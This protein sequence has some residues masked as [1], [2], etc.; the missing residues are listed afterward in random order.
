MKKL[1]NYIGIFVILLATALSCQEDDAT[2]GEINAPSNLE[3]TTEIVG[4]SEPDF[5]N[6]DGSGNVIITATADKAISYKFLFS[7]QT[8]QNSPSGEYTKQFTTTGVNTYTITVI[9]YGTGGTATTASVEVTVLSN[10]SDD[11][12]VQ[13]LTAGTSKVWYW[14]AAQPGHLGVGPND[15]SDSNG[16]PSYYAA[17][18]FEKE[19][20]PTSSC[21][22]DNVLTFSLDGET[23]KYTLDNGGLTFFN[24]S[25]NSLGGSTAADDQCLP[26]DTTGEKV[27][28]LGPS[29]SLVPAD[30]KRGTT[31]SFSDNGFMG[32]YIGT[33]TYEILSITE[34]EMHVRAVMG[35]NEALAWYHIF[36]T[37]PVDQQGGGGVEEPDYDTLMWSDEFDVD[38]APN[39]DNWTMEIGN[40]QN[41]WGNNE[42]QYYLADNAVVEGGVLKITAKAENSNGFDYTSARMKTEN[43]YEFTYG[44][45]EIRAK[46]PTGG[47]TWPAL[48]MLGEDY[49]TNTWP[50]C[51]EIDIMEHVGNQQNTIHGTLHYPGNSGGNANTGSTTVET[52]S[53]EFH[54]YTMIWSPTQI[55]FFVDDVMY[56]SYTNDSSSPFNSDF[57]LIF[58]V[59]MGGNF[60]GAIDPGYTESTIEVDYVKVYQYFF[61]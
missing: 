32:Y 9:A 47:G 31:M 22:Y 30:Q 4:Q 7:D 46:L 54:I 56:H 51:G 61:S 27:V 37:T 60:G 21:L 34:N 44:K 25:F 53:S 49:A 20:S 38:G 59:A 1:I 43:K 41:G 33:S 24:S 39:P 12:A 3:I 23:I 35:G 29:N 5:P 26:W 42:S 50:G 15:T 58:N 10:F 14:Y 36:T 55:R 45:V 40:G 57:F 6:G 18:P 2:F 8:S 16:E 17:A 11:E 13:L 19:G 48:W 28:S 52:A